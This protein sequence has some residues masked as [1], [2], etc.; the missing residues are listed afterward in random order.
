MLEALPVYWM[1]PS[2]VPKGILDKIR[3]LFFQLLWFGEAGMKKLVPASWKKLAVPKSL[4]GWGLKKEKASSPKISW[5][6]GA[7]KHL[8]F[9]KSLAAKNAWR[10]IQGQGFGHK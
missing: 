2:W 3:Q 7:E 6:L 8:L 9:S 10:L 5:T 1:S 4:G